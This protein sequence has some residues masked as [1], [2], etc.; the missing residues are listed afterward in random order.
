RILRQQFYLP[1]SNSVLTLL[2]ILG[3]MSFRAY[4][5]PDSATGIAK[6]SEMTYLTLGKQKLLTLPGENFVNTVYGNYTDAAHSSTG[7]G[8]EVNPAP[9]CEICGDADL[10]AVGVTNDMTGYVVPPNDFVLNPTQPYLNGVHDRFDENHY[11]E[12][13]S[14]GPD[15]QRVIAETFAGMVE[16][17]GG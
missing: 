8:P 6:K 13:N 3:T 17:F 14:M 5:W 7:M 10:I 4:P 2:A 12:T 9:L 16:R 1:V 11:P 15:T